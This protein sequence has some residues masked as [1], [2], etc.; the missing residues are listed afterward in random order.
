MKGKLNALAD[1][2]DTICDFP[3]IDYTPEFLENLEYV[4]YHTRFITS[5]FS[6]IPKGYSLGND[7][8]IP[9]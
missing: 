9:C 6:N 1:N 5:R 4:R 3:L 2:I 7:K 8:Q